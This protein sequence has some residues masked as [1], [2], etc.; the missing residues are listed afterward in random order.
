MENV[1]RVPDNILF[2]L[3]K[4]AGIPHSFR[5]K[6]TSHVL[7]HKLY[8]MTS[9]L[10]RGGM[11][12]RT[13][14]LKQRI[15]HQ[16]YS[17]TRHLWHTT[18][19]CFGTEV[20]SLGSHYNKGVCGVNPY[21]NLNNRPIRTL[22][23]IPTSQIAQC[24]FIT[25]NTQLMLQRKQN[26]MRLLKLWRLQNSVNPFAGRLSWPQAWEGFT[27]NSWPFVQRNHSNT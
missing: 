12:R 13:G 1:L 17:V 14:T 16:L 22:K 23:P 11:G 3:L 2:L 19:T 21:A 9:C 4:T 6:K 8:K 26:V 7:M 5:Q 25:K 18:A 27:A 10:K 24:I 20:S 15:I